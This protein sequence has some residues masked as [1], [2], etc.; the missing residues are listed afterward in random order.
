MPNEK[1]RIDVYLHG[2]DAV[3]SQ[4]ENGVSS[5]GQL[6]TPTQNSKDAARSAQMSL[7]VDYSKKIAMQG[8]SQIGDITGNYIMQSQITG[9]MNAAALGMTM[10]QF[11]Y[12]TIAGVYQL[13]SQTVS[14][15]IQTTKQNRDIDL[16]RERTGNNNRNNSEV[17]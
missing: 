2:G 16:F 11:P 9:V 10:L 8:I 6:T 5:D 13:A 17:D 7:I 1:G 14:T 12:G 15:F 4:I 3:S